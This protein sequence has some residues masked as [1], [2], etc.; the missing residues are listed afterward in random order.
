MTRRSVGTKCGATDGCDGGAGRRADVGECLVR[1]GGPRVAPGRAPRRPSPPPRSAPVPSIVADATD[2]R[3]AR[4]LL[5]DA[6][7]VRPGGRHHRLLRALRFLE[8]QDLAPLF[9]RLRENEHA[10]LRVHGLLGT[11]ELATPRG[12]TTENLVDLERDDQRAEVIGAALD[13]GLL[14]DQ[15]LD[16]LLAWPGPGRRGQAAAGH[17]TRGRGAGGRRLAG[18]R[19]DG[20]RAGD[21]RLCRRGGVAGDV[22]ATFETPAMAAPDPFERGARADPGAA[23]AQAAQGL[24]RRG[25]AA[26]LLHQMGD[27]RGTRGLIALNNANVPGRDTVRATLLETA[28]A[29]GLDR[30]GTWAYSIASE[31]DLPPRLG[32]LALEVAAG[33]GDARAHRRWAEQFRAARDD[34]PRRTRL[35]LTG[36]SFAK[37]ADP[38][39]FNVT[40]V[41]SDPFVAAVGR[42]ARAVADASQQAADASQPPRQA[43]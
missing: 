11:A 34:L 22:A 13:G 39:V 19:G 3:S 31:P 15:T 8:D 27:A 25:L 30:A 23:S 37:V 17:P 43:S 36:L 4:V 16:E 42:A 24:G 6:V 41:D 18:A 33:F 1:T 29:H 5:Q 26:L 20:R 40:A 28:R 9:R 38:E 10:A 7:K 12:V 32:E 2:T 35:A 21:A 14:S